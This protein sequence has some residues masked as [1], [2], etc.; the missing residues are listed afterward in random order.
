MTPESANKIERVT[1]GAAALSFLRSMYSAESD[2]TY[3][4]LVDIN[5][6]VMSGHEFVSVL[7]RDPI[8]H[9]LVVFMLTTSKDPMDIS[10]AYGN[11]VAGYIVKERAGD[12]FLE[13]ATMLEQ[14]WRVVEVPEVR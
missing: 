1:D 13:L 5:M 10:L 11:H 3:I 4:L 12:D 8:L 6:P 2:A 7:R 9:K 14:Y